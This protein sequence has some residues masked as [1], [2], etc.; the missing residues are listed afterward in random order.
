[1]RYGF[2]AGSKISDYKH[3]YIVTSEGLAQHCAP[4]FIFVLVCANLLDELTKVRVS[5]WVTMRK[6]HGIHVD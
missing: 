3:L 2:R 4:D 1:M 5:E 6:V